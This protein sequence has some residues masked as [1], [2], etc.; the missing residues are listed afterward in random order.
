V[1][2]DPSAL[3]LIIVSLC[4]LVLKVLADCHPLVKLRLA[5]CKGARQGNKHVSNVLVNLPF[6]SI[7]YLFRS[8]IAFVPKIPK[9]IN[10]VPEVLFTI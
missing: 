10:K 1:L 4:D 7:D 3:L 5:R 8:L 9:F 2:W 6:K